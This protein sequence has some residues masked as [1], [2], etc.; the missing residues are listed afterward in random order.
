MILFTITNRN[1]AGQLGI[2]PVFFDEADPRPAREQ[3]HERYAHGG[4]WHKFSGFE[5]KMDKRGWYLA[6]PEDPPM[7]EIARGKLRDELI[8]LFDHNWV[9]IVQKDDTFEVARVD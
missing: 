2:L 3:I 8:L 9:A 6:Y 4:G 1:R 7:R 5:L